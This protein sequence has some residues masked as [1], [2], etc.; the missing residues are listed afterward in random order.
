MP[1]RMSS[2]ALG[3]SLRE[4]CADE[5]MP[6]K[7]TVLRWI[8][9]DNKLYKDFRDQYA[10]AREIQLELNEDEILDIADDGTNDYVDRTRRDGSTETVFDNEHFQR[11]KL[12]IEARERK[13]ARMR[14]GG[15]NKGHGGTNPKPEEQKPQTIKLVPSPKVTEPIT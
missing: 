13:I 14:G 9:S 1:P 2:L 6:D 8:L 10:R 5:R 4:I 12:R 15:S 3:E 11:S 7:A